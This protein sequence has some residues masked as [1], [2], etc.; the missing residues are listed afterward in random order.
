MRSMMTP[1]N[2]NAAMNLMGGGNSALGGGG[3]LGAMGGSPGSF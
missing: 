2:I 1:E 3:G